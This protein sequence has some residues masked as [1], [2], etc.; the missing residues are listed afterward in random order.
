MSSRSTK[1]TERKRRRNRKR[2]RNKS[3]VL[4]LYALAALTLVAAVLGVVAFTIH[5]VPDEASFAEP[6]TTPSPTPAVE[7]VPELTLVESLSDTEALT[8]VV[9]GDSTGYED[10]QWVMTMA[11]DLSARYNRTTEVSRWNRDTLAYD[12]TSLVGTGT[13]A[14]LTIWNGSA[15]G[16]APVYSSTN[17][18]ALIPMADPS[19]IIVSHGH[20][21]GPDPVL[22]ISRLLTKITNVYPETPLAVTVQNP[23]L[24]SDPVV[25]A[26]NSSAIRNWIGEH[27]DWVAIDVYTAFTTQ[28]D[29]ESLYLD[30]R[31]P[32][33]AG[34]RVWADTVE[35][36]LGI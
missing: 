14:P 5:R 26:E 32:N 30:A 15:P 1:A 33:V 3:R 25:A 27:A 31:H 12:T 21:T 28:P 6:A 22:D 24:T 4:S 18:D 11:K 7:V 29:M 10:Q 23:A 8:I 16:E 34:G 13:G 20:N 2:K 35:V 19:M 9:V 36:A 17:L